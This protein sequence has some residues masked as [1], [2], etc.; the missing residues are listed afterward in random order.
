MYLR[1]SQLGVSKIGLLILLATV[2]FFLLCAFRMIPVYMDDR[3]IQ[4][5]LRSLEDDAATI[6]EMS[7]RDIRRKISNFYMVNNVRNHS[8][9]ELEIDRGPDGVIVSMIYEVRLPLIYNI[10]VV[11]SFENEWDS[12][13]PDECC[14]PLSE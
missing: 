5:A 11:M 4:T 1:N 7:D 12:S 3:Y 6:N 13:R 2:A 8:A 9:N 10:D 14:K